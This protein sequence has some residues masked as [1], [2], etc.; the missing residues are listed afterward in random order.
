MNP[1]RPL[2]PAVKAE[3]VAD[4]HG[5]TRDRITE[6]NGTAEVFTARLTDLEAWYSA[7][8]GTITR[9][10]VDQ[11]ACISNERTRIVLWTLHTDTGHGRGVP[12]RVHALALDTDQIDA[13][14]ANAVTPAA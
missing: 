3:V 6:H 10:Y 11:R 13:D 8:G 14:C 5:L 12:V 1:I 4:L 7:L 2:N 9:H